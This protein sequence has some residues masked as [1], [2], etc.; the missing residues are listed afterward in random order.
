MRIGIDCRLWNETGVGRY[1][2]NLVQ[3]LQILDK[4]NEY[5]L[6][7][8]SKDY[9][10]IKNQELR[11][12]DEKWKL[13]KA[14]IRW[15]TVKEQLLFPKILN[16]ENLDL[17]H[18]PYFSVPIGYK[19]PYIVT[20]H[21]LI[22]H[23]FPTGQATTLPKPVYALKLRGYRYVIE[24]AAKNAQKIITVSKATK[25]EIVKHLRVSKKK[26]VVTYEGVDF[27]NSEFR[28]QNLELEKLEKQKY[29]LYV[30]NAYPHK[31][32]EM[33]IEG[34]KLLQESSP[35]TSKN[36]KLVLVGKEDYF[37]KRLKEKVRRLGLS[38]SV[39][40]FGYASDEALQALYTHAQALVMPSLMEGFGLPLLEAMITNCFVIASDIPSLKEIAQDAAIYIN[41]NDSKTVKHVLQEVMTMS[42]EKKQH[43][44]EKG[45]K[46]A[47]TFTWESMAKQTLAVYNSL[48]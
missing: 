45:Q 16:K 19:K 4:T 15:H 22:L 37:Y 47:Q 39:I 42:E 46:R 9:D 41:P 17:M 40:F 12:K 14:D 7:V 28:M 29:F 35:E 25:D 23:N 10:R 5:V 36:I 3:Q 8:K 1:I 43:Y 2:R 27:K 24:H 21:D 31:N 30:G 6:F 33:L 48:Q 44:K 34:F 20:I 26:I 11:I 32:L 13:V 38:D 18:F